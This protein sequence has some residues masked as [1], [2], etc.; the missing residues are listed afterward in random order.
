MSCDHE[1]HD[2]ECLFC[3]EPEEAD[4]QEEWR[5]YCIAAL[6]GG[7]SGPDAVEAANTCLAGFE[8]RFGGEE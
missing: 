2:G 5:Q 8:Y 6:I 3:G 4:D 1:F 7:A